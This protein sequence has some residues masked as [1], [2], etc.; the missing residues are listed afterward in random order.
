MS[1]VHFSF[2]R[3]RKNHR[4]GKLPLGEVVLQ[5]KIPQ[6]TTLTAK[7]RKGKKRLN[8]RRRKKETA[9][10][11]FRRFQKYSQ[12]ERT[13]TTKDGSN[14][15]TGREGGREGPQTSSVLC[16]SWDCAAWLQKICAQA[17]ATGSRSA[18]ETLAEELGFLWSR[19]EKEGGREFLLFTKL[20]LL[21]FS[22]NLIF[23]GKHTKIRLTGAHHFRKSN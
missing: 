8:Q 21:Q 9:L 11:T 1:T 3:K 6:L 2:V 5:T 23:H 18:E 16:S 14:S 13:E 4:I 20:P 15:R 12:T 19:R 7:R 22:P 17:T 10:R